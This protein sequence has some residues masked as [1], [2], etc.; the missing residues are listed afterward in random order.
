[1]FFRKELTIIDSLKMLDIQGSFCHG[2]F[3]RD[4]IKYNM[5]GQL[6]SVDIKIIVE[7]ISGGIWIIS[8]ENYFG[9]MVLQ[10]LFYLSRGSHIDTEYNG[11]KGGESISLGCSFINQRGNCIRSRKGIG[12]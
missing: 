7:D 2:K 11:P 10:L 6:Y 3:I 1:M 8:K 12:K 5:G 9:G 4:L